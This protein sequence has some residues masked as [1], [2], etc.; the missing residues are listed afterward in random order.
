MKFGR[1][2]TAAA[3]LTLTVTC[4]SA[5][6]ASATRDT[7]KP[8]TK[9]IIVWTTRTDT[10]AEHL[11]IARAD[12]SRQRVLTPALPNFDDL[13]AQVSPDGNWV[14]YEHDNPDTAN[15]HL[16]HPDGTNDHVVDVG[17]VNECIVAAEPTWLSNDRIAFSLVK[18]PFDPVTGNAASAVLWSSRLDGSDVRRLSPAGI[19][20]AYEDNYLHI[21][22]D[23]SYLT[24]QRIR[25]ADHHSALFRM[26]T[27]GR[28]VQQLTPWE[29][30]ADVND[31]STAR[32]GPTKDLLVFESYG[33][34]TS[35]STFADIATVPATCTSLADCTSKIHWLTDNQ[36]TGRRN[37]NPQWSP[38]GANLVFTDRPNF[39]DQNVEIFTMRY[40]G[41]ERRK[42]ST[43]T[44]FDYRPTW[45]TS[46][47]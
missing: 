8:S 39:T 26:T 2:I 5:A 18:G 47:E 9:G 27:S 17:C 20:G 7:G 15:I 35:E 1:T 32:R 22:T 21:S 34:G 10:G 11:L 19:D 40:L 6:Q 42:I 30:S 36:A 43:S 41:T 24:F 4:A 45:G 3:A 37:A 38:D 31:L 14:A 28:A 12:S 25:N 44:A 23:R 46:D 33:R 13:N 29:I 16:V